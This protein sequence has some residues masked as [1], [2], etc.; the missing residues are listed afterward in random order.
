MVKSMKRRHLL[1]ALGLGCIGFGIAPEI[2]AKTVRGYFAGVTYS[3]DG[4]LKD[5]LH[6]IHNFNH[7]HHDD[8]QIDSN[9]YGIF[10]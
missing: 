6:K 1:K 3:T 10:E 8:L 2:L 7:P 4:G 9:L 5:Y